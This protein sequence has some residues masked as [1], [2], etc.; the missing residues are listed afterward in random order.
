MFNESIQY[1]ILRIQEI[2]TTIYPDQ[3]ICVIL[4]IT[5]SNNIEPA[6]ELS[7][8]NAYDLLKLGNDKIIPINIGA[9]KSSYP[10]KFIL[11][12]YS[13][14]RVASYPAS[15]SIIPNG[16]KWKIISFIRH[17]LMSK[18]PYLYEIIKSIYLSRLEKIQHSYSRIINLRN[19]KNHRLT[20]SND[21]ILIGLHWLDVGGAESFATDCCTIANEINKKLFIFSAHISRPY[22]YE[23]LKLIGSIYEIDRQI[24]PLLRVEFISKFIHRFKIS[25]VHNHHCEYLYE[26]LPLIR[27]ITPN[28]K[29]IDSLHIDEKN[30]FAGGFPRISIVWSNYIDYH[31]VISLRLK[32]LLLSNGIHSQRILY[33]HLSKDFDSNKEFSINNSLEKHKFKFCFVGRM[34]GQK[35]P[36]LAFKLFIYAIKRFKSLNIKLHID[37]VGDGFYHKALESAIA[38]SA[39]KDN[40]SIYP[41]NSNVESIISENDLLLLTSENE[42]ITLVA[43]EALR[44]GTLVVSSNVGAQNE[45]IPKELLIN[46]SPLKAL[47]DW[48]VIVDKLLDPDF[49]TNQIIEF[50]HMGRTILNSPS[51][52]EIISNQYGDIK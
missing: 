17:T 4:K 32:N 5:S 21:N 44:N 19:P 46:P 13:N 49:L 35:R 18:L 50:K 31:H 6:S 3:H 45:L 40:F 28:I 36:L 30:R 39:F 52:K 12:T 11:V 37:I 2:Y 10:S 7:I 1:E 8:T 27:L 34:T 42:G 23:K 43:Y 24:P 29:F 48:K 33:G 20:E 51:A 16:V 26:S 25:T 14:D 15:K 41:S 47:S 38:R 22:Y 9:R